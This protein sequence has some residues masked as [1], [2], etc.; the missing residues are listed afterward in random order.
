MPGIALIATAAGHPCG[1]S[2]AYRITAARVVK[3]VYTRDLKSLGGQTPPCRFKSGPGHKQVF[4]YCALPTPKSLHFPL[5]FDTMCPLSRTL[6]HYH[7]QGSGGTNAPI[8][9]G[10]R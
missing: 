1:R 5:Q 9:W 7:A 10:Y 8:S 2:N 3:L 4:Q 6:G